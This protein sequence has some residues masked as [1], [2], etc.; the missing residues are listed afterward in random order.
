M[1]VVHTSGDTGSL[2][3]Q[4]R[5]PKRRRT[6]NLAY[7]TSTLA[8]KLGGIMTTNDEGLTYIVVV[9]SDMRFYIWRIDNRQWAVCPEYLTFDSSEYYQFSIPGDI[10]LF[11]SRYSAS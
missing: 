2:L 3:P 9:R 6:S 10:S 5:Q 8:I 4:G 1:A 7:A 11:M